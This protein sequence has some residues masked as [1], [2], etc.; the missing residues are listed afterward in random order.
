MNLS[1]E[2]FSKI[3]TLMFAA[4]L[5]QNKWRDFLE[6]LAGLTGVRAHM[7][8]HD[9]EGNLGLNLLSANYDP[10]YVKSYADHYSARNT[11]VEGFFA[12][13]VGEVIS[14]ESMASREELVKTE[15][16]SDWVLP[17]EDIL[18]GG[19]VI[20]FK[21]ATRMFVLGGNIRR[22][23]E[24][25]EQGWLE[26]VAL[27]SP[28]LQHAIAINRILAEK[29]V[30]EFAYD[31]GINSAGAAIMVVNSLRRIVFAN[32]VAQDMLTSG[33]TVRIDGGGHL[34]FSADSADAA[35]RQVIF[36]LNQMDTNVSSVFEV[37]GLTGTAQY[38]CRTA[39]FDPADHNA[40]PFG[41]LVDAHEPCVLLTVSGVEEKQTSQSNL[42]LRFGIT[43]TEADVVLLIME[44]L[45]PNDISHQRGVSVHTTRN[46]LK[47]AMSK[48]DVRRQ[49]DLVRLLK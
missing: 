21:E 16:Y 13:G 48:M 31:E 6:Y 30:T 44:G 11:W 47:S 29:T 24:H 12:H 22:K 2:E 14:A 3:T 5:D 25:L 43:A 28:H 23:D 35:F 27:L 34:D 15:F 42:V 41:V 8:G 32:Q 9:F 39:R 45:S 19:G 1:Q 36:A 33:K 46:Q 4:A 38:V 18:A 49:V 7:F 10:D 17:Q 26:L 37:T 20:L 40:S